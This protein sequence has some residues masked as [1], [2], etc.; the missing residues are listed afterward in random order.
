MQHM[1]IHETVMEQRDE[2][3]SP[4]KDHPSMDIKTTPEK[5]DEL[6]FQAIRRLNAKILGLVLG[7][8][9]GLLLFVA[10]L[11]LVIKGG[12]PVGPH[13]SLLGQFFPGYTVTVTGSFLGLGYGFVVGFGMGWLI[14]WVYNA[15]V[16]FR[17]ERTSR[18]D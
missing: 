6:L 4:E 14:G 8:T 5:K 9:C 15:V 13:L 10:T 18:N 2:I 17:F 1:N 3:Q 11:F 16:T 7:L 12:D